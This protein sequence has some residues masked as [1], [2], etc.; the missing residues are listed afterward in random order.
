MRIAMTG[1]TGLLGRNLLFEILK[2]NLNGLDDLEIL[3]LGRS[4]KTAPLEERIDRI[5]V[6]DGYPYIGIDGQ[7]NNEIKNK[8]NSCI[9]P[10]SFDLTVD[11][12]GISE[13]DLAKLK[14]KPIDHFFHV[15]ALTDFRSDKS[16]EAKLEEV[17]VNGTK[18]L[19]GLLDK[20][21]IGQAV[22]IGSA[23][24]CGSK[25]G[26][27]KPDYINLNEKFRNP[28]ER[29]KLKAEVAFREFAQKHKLPYKI[30]RPSTIC[31]RLIEKPI[32]SI[33]KFDVFYAWGAFFLRYKY[34]LMQSADAIYEKP[35]EIPIR[36]HFNPNSGLN[37]IPADYAA[38]VLYKVSL[39]NWKADS[40]HLC[41]NA[42]TPHEQYVGLILDELSIKGCSFVPQEP[43][44]KNEA[45]KFYYKTVG[46]LFTPYAVSEPILFDLSN[47]YNKLNKEGL[48]C[49]AVDKPALGKLIGYAKKKMFNLSIK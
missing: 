48:A 31:G 6:E 26:V 8:L 21:D 20:L 14:G 24:S 41:N 39:S 7:G 3:I 32:G 12:L 30:F 11:G 42:E 16:V 10:V 43:D 37:I 44:D 46:K 40:I 22:Y 9:T 28:Y 47:V 45:E 33:H 15:A 36:I 1:A 25:T 19:L 18:R 34:K 17:N 38:K 35:I 4:Q 29:S 13:A 27:V 2:Q 49:P 23:Y 5:L